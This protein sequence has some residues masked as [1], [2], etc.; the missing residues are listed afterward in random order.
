M[1]LTL[2]SFSLLEHRL[3]VQADTGVFG[4]FAQAHKITADVEAAD[5]VFARQQRTG[6][7][8]RHKPVLLLFF[9]PNHLFSGA[10]QKL[11]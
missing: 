8:L 9:G 10:A 5:E 4:R 7:L 1:G 3:Q 11:Q 2:I 6:R